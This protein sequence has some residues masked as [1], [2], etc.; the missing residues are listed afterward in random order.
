[1]QSTSHPQD[2][3]LWSYDLTALY[4][5][6]IYL[7]KLDGPVCIM[8]ALR[9]QQQLSNSI[10]MN[11]NAPPKTQRRSNPATSVQQ[12]SPTPTSRALWYHTA[13]A[14]QYARPVQLLRVNRGNPQA[15][16]KCVRYNL[17]LIRQTLS[18]HTAGDR[19]AVC[20]ISA[21]HYASPMMSVWPALH[22][23]L[24]MSRTDPA[25]DMNALE[26]SQG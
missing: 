15:K 20:I 26:S 16:W 24:L 25:Y 2:Q 12:P 14:S 5:S 9:Q 7:L 1:M 10:C 19:T 22:L 6:T 13:A 3:C 11:I 18:P 8:Q 21:A 23:R 4:K 17:L